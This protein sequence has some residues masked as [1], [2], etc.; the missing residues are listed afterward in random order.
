M[1]AAT[2]RIRAG[3][4]Q[5]VI[6]LQTHSPKRSLAGHLF[7]LGVYVF[8][9]GA[10]AYLAFLKQGGIAGELFVAYASS[11]PLTVALQTVVEIGWARQKLSAHHVIA[12]CVSAVLACGLGGLLLLFGQQIVVGFIGSAL[13]VW[14]TRYSSA[15]SFLKPPT[16]ADV[17]ASVALGEHRSLRALAAIVAAV[18]LS[19]AGI[20]LMWLA[21]YGELQRPGGISF[22]I[23]G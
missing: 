2:D 12:G 1:D 17:S 10:L 4:P 16:L 11:I 21:F 7:T 22:T 9:F 14:V 5:P 18:V 13:V 19:A 6:A 23:G 15:A 8:V 3:E 20:W